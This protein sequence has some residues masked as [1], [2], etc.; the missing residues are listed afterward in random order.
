MRPFGSWQFLA[1]YQSDEPALQKEA[2][3]RNLG[4]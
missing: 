1:G 4:P 3:G 2:S